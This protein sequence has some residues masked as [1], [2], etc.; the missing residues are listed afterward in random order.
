MLGAVDARFFCGLEQGVDEAHVAGKENE[1]HRDEHSSDRTRE[2]GP[3][4]RPVELHMLLGQSRA[5]AVVHLGKL[6]F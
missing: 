5:N 1:D 6:F 4:F 3:T 2:P